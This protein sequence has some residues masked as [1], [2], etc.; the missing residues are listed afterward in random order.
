MQK[1]E[2]K[3]R[4]IICFSVL[5][6]FI[7][8]ISRAHAVVTDHVLHNLTHFST[9]MQHRCEEFPFLELSEEKF[10]VMLTVLNI[11]VNTIQLISSLGVTS[12]ELL[13]MSYEELKNMIRLSPNDI[14]RISQCILHTSVDGQTLNNTDLRNCIPPEDIAM[15]NYISLKSLLFRCSGDPDFPRLHLTRQ[16]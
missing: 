15:L 12:M 14:W 11:N 13:D 7:F 9:E 16:E 6:G 10:T 2:N 3:N 5:L 4:K 1:C 8:L